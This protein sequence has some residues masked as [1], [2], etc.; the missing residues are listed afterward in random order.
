VLR[1]TIEHDERIGVSPQIQTFTV[2]DQAQARD[3]GGALPTLSVLRHR[4]RKESASAQTSTSWERRGDVN[5]RD[6]GSAPRV[7]QH[8]RRATMPVI[9]GS[10]GMVKPSNGGVAP[11]GQP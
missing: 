9:Q 6:A 10:S 5:V 4:A 3:G 1:I 11:S 7:L 8:I 2:S